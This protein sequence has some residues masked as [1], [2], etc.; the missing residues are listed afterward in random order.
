MNKRPLP[1]LEQLIQ[2]LKN[3]IRNIDIQIENVNAVISEQIE[4]LKPFREEVVMLV[5]TLN[6]RRRV[7]NDNILCYY[8]VIYGSK[9]LCH[10]PQRLAPYPF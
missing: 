5:R 2:N 10:H 6:I 3:D 1:E 4:E 7:I 8:S 9:R